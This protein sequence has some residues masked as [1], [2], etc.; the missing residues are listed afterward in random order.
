MKTIYP[1]LHFVGVFSLLFKSVPGQP[2]GDTAQEFL[3]ELPGMILQLERMF[4]QSQTAS[5]E[6]QLAC[7]T[8]EQVT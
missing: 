3:E 7:R 6:G 4:H 8:R 2:T 1:I 5:H